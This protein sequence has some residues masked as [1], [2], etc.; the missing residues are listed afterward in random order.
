VFEPYFT[1]RTDGSGLGLSV[2]RSI[3]REAGGEIGVVSEL[4]G[5]T[6]FEVCLPRATPR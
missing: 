2:C 4:G 1:T 5:G 6:R 3:V